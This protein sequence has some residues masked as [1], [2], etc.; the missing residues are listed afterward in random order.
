M[1]KKFK[2]GDINLSVLYNPKGRDYDFFDLSSSIDEDFCI[3][4]YRCELEDL[5]RQEGMS[6]T[7]KARDNEGGD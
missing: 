2:S 4:L 6:E 3:F 5:L 1:V 7:S